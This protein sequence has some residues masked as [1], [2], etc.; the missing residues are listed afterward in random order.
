MPRIGTVPL[1]TIVRFC[2]GSPEALVHPEAARE[3]FFKFFVT[4]CAL[5]RSLPDGAGVAGECA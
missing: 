2:A 4:N 3:L 1:R 5:Q